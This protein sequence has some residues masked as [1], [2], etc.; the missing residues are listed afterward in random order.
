MLN[1]TIG[2]VMSNKDVLSV[3][4]ES[5]PYFRTREFSEIMLE[6]ERMMLDFLAAPENS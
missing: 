1:F 2:P 5:S 3:S 6:N 4:A